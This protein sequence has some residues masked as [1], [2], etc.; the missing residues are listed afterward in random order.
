LII[1]HPFTIDTHIFNLSVKGSY[2][3]KQLAS[4]RP[5]SRTVI[6]LE[7][8]FWDYAL[9]KNGISGSFK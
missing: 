9:P 7:R 8:A 4:H 5:A 1:I 6:Q 3:L 2:F